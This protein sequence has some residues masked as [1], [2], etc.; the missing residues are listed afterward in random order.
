[1]GIKKRLQLILTGL[2]IIVIFLLE[3]LLLCKLA[4]NQEKE[5]QQAIQTVLSDENVIK[6]ISVET[7][8]N[9][10]DK[11]VIGYLTIDSINLIKAPIKEGIEMTILNKYIGHFPDSAYLEGNVALAGHNR[12]YEKNYFENLKEIKKGDIIEYQTKSETKKYKVTEIKKITET[13][14]D[15]IRNTKENKITLITCVENKPYFRLC[16]V[17]EQIQ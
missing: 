7:S 1:M 16:V 5:E 10:K 15:V 3:L 17:G 2:I 9:E 14:I 6:D 8:N 13:D 4:S 11:N 12:G